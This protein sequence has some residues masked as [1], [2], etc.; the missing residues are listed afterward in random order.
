MTDAEEPKEELERSEGRCEYYSYS[1][2][3][4]KPA[5]SV[6]FKHMAHL[7]RIKHFSYITLVLIIMI[8]LVKRYK[9]FI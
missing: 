2:A 3:L 6:T 4:S 7:N 9:T 8:F 1:Y 5:T